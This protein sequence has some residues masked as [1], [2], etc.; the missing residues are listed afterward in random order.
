MPLSSPP[1]T[2]PVRRNRWRS[3]M[4]VATGLC[5]VLA[6][7]PAVAPAAAEQKPDSGGSHPVA[8]RQ[9]DLDFMLGSYRCEFDGNPTVG[10]SVVFS[11]TVPTL[12]GTFYQMD[13]T[14]VKPNVPNLHGRWVLGWSEA[15]SQFVSYY[16]DE[17]VMHGSSFSPGRV[18]RD[19]TFEGTYF[20]AARGPIGVRDVFVIHNNS[21][22]EINEYVKIGGGDWQFFDHQDCRR[23]R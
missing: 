22:F 6:I 1:S 12:S 17:N 23:R 16:Y 8:E 9:H 18:G 3:V 5:L 2:A 10:D 13:I 11:R 7:G 20:L 14:Q 21:H 15:E 19:M 4:T